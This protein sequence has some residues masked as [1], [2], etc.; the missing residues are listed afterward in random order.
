MRQ[1]AGGGRL[2][3]VTGVAG[4]VHI[5][6]PLLFFFMFHVSD[7]KNISGMNSVSSL[8]KMFDR[9]AGWIN[10]SM[11]CLSWMSMSMGEW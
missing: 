9:T 10:R 11:D 5:N 1:G 4:S 8:R 3:E 6:S 7:F 2:E